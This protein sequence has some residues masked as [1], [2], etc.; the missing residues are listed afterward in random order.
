MTNPKSIAVL[1]VAM[2]ALVAVM[3]FSI[4]VD[5]VEEPEYDQD[6]GTKYS[7]EIQF[8]FTGKDALSVTWDFGDGSEP[9]TAFYPQHTFPDKGTYYVT[10]DAYN[11]YDPDG[12]GEGSHSIAVYKITIAGYPWIDFNSN[13]GSDV[14]TIQQEDF[15]VAAEKPSDPT[16]AGYTFAGWFTD[17]ELTEAYD[18][19][20]AVKKPITLYAKWVE[21]VTVSFDLAGGVGSIP[22]QK[23]DVGDTAT[24]PA[25]PTRD[26]FRFLGW[27]N[28]DVRWSFTDP[29]TESMTLTAHWYEIPAG[30]TMFRVTFDGA[31]GTPDFGSISCEEG[32]SIT[33]PGAF[34]DGYDFDG[35]Y[36]GE[37]RIGGEGDVYKPEA[38]V[39]L[40]AH[41]IESDEPVGPGPDEPGESGDE[42]SAWYWIAAGILAAVFAIA[43]F[44]SRNWMIAILAVA[45]AVAAIAL[46]VWM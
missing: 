24:E 19:E 2:A 43:A 26:G 6:L 40:T 21:Q 23:I 8:S 17:D 29:V 11:T 12:D 16:K 35:W 34:R 32:E 39:T 13:G 37:T 1:A 22:E 14:S 25:E 9:V 44:L 42:G 20:T 7:Y 41:W 27:Y 30:V 15:G 18:W 45:C 36:S 3:S 38:D 28:G 46:Y 4:A 5:G 10:Q 31:G 33:L